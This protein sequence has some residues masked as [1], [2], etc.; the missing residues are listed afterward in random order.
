MSVKSILGLLV[1]FEDRYISSFDDLA[2]TVADLK[3][4]GYKIALTQGVYDLLHLGHIKYLEAAKACADILVVGIDSD[5]WARSR[6]GPTR[7]IVP[8]DERLQMLV[9]LRSVDIVTVIEGYGAGYRDLIEVIQPDVLIISETTSD[10]SEDR[11]EFFRQNAGEVRKLPPQATVSTTGR[12]RNLVV[13][14]AVEH[15]RQLHQSL[16]ETIAALEKG[17]GGGQ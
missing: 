14:G 5:A 16:G 11:M 17:K 1:S 9:S 10:I 4:M 7:P 6:K 15:L 13:D 3:R 12:I 2:A 8:Q